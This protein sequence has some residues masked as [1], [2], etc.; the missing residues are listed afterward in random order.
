MIRVFDLKLRS[1]FLSALAILSLTIAFTALKPQSSEAT[2]PPFCGF[3]A[4]GRCLN[5]GYFTNEAIHALPGVPGNDL[6]W[7]PIW[8]YTDS[9]SGFTGPMVYPP[10]VQNGN[11]NAVE[12]FINWHWVTLNQPYCGSPFCPTNYEQP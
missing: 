9:G 2:A 7:P 8:F 6:V 3:I 12:E 4:Y 5:T 1:I 11:P 10:G